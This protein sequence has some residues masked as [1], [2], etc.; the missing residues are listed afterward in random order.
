MEPRKTRRRKRGGSD[1]FFSRAQSHQLTPTIVN[2]NSKFVVVTYWWGR[3]NLNKNMQR[4]CPEDLEQGQSLTVQPILYEEM[5]ANWSKACKKSKCNFLAEE[6]PEFAVKGG[7]QHAINFKPYFIELALKACAPR[8]VLYIDGDMK[9][10]I[11]PSICDI[12]EVDFMARGWNSDIRPDIARGKKKFCLDPYV[13]ETSGGTMFFG[14]TVHGH[15]LL[16]FW[17][18]ETSKYPGK[19][20]DR[21]LSLA[22]MRNSLLAPLSTIQLP[23]EYLWLSMYYDEELKSRRDYFKKDISISHPECLTGED[24]A[25]SEGASSNRYP[26]RYDATMYKYLECD[27]EEVYEYIFFENEEQ[28]LPFR[29]YFKVAEK[30]NVL[31]LIPYKSKYGSFNGVAKKN[32]ELQSQVQLKVAGKVVVLSDKDLKTDVLHKESDSTLLIPTILKYLENGQT[33]I[34]VPDKATGVRHLVNK[35]NKQMLDFVARNNNTKR[36]RSRP[37]YYLELDH[38]YPIYFGPNNRVLRQ[39]LLMSES[40][41]SMEKLFNRTFLFLTRI[42]C[43]WI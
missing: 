28:A 27:W 32:A 5:I 2:E 12:S 17:Q 16:K 31:D 18:K 38:E 41:K 9:I 24:R 39:L 4:P 19:A 14:Q 7:Y 22:V 11:Y 25:S 40:F 13:F 23:V 3:G 26:A 1:D 21:I 30:Q 10:D 8:G 37:E 36:Y 34:Y 35:A 15:S 42:H 29:K 43:G 6:Y 33:V 20:D